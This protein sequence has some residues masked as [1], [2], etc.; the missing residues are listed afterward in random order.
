MFGIRRRLANLS[1]LMRPLALAFVGCAI[2]A[3]GIGYVLTFLYRTLELPWIFY[4][5]TIQ[6]VPQFW[7]GILF[8]LLG[9]GTLGYGIWSLSD[10]VV[11]PINAQTQNDEVLLDYRRTDRAPRLAVLSGGPGML[12]LASLGRT[13]DTMTCITPVQDPVEYYYR[14]SSLFNFEKVVF[15]V[16]TPHP[17]DVT[18]VLDNGVRVKP[19]DR[20]THDERYVE[21]YVVD[22]QLESTTTPLHE[23]AVTRATLDA[24][25]QADAI[26]LGPGSLFESIIPNLLMPA[27]REALLASKAKKI[28]ICSIMTEPGLTQGFTVADHIR[29]IVRYGGFAPDYVLVNAQRIDADVQRI[30]AAARQTPVYLA[31]EEY[32]ETVVQAIDRGAG[33]GVMIEGSVIIEADLATAVIQ[34]TASLEDPGKSRT[35][36]VLRHDPDKVA[37]AITSIMR[38]GR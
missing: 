28:Y 21:R 16:P 34:L 24:I 36:R 25:A 5:L 1:H 14:A 10:K 38:R 29:Q 11:I 7:R 13:V 12:V 30:Y 37:A 15:V 19:S 2:L 17:I 4:Y 6:F 35:V 23:V 8:L 20:V 32:E 18:F 26:I 3:L 27:V 9:V 31:P 22:V 33:S